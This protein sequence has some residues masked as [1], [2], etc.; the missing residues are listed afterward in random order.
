MRF[1]YGRSCA[2][3]VVVMVVAWVLFVGMVGLTFCWKPGCF[4]A[5][6]AQHNAAH[7]GFDKECSWV[8]VIVIGLGS[9]IVIQMRCYAPEST[10]SSNV[11]VH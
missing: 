5:G 1:L 4:C 8:V 10:T 2:A 7:D 11:P 9:I 3:H 6:G